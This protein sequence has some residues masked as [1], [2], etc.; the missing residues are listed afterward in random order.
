MKE[1]N[2]KIRNMCVHVTGRQKKGI[3]MILNIV[4]QDTYK[5]IKYKIIYYF[6]LN[7]NCYLYDV[8]AS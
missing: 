8:H 3:K 2:E 1:K 4:K 5:N 7:I 6:I